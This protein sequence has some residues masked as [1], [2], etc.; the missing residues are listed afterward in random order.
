MPGFGGA[1]GAGSVG[2]FPEL[3]KAPPNFL[4]NTPG[5]EQAQGQALDTLAGAEGQY[6]I[7]KTM[8]PA[9]LGLQG[10]RLQTDQDVATDRLREDLANRGIFTPYGASGYSAAGTSPAGGGVG[11]ALYNRNVATP[12]GRQRQDLGAAGAGAYS[13]LSGAYGGAQLGYNQDMYQALLGRANDAFSAMPL[14]AQMGGYALPDMAM[15]SFSAPPQ[16]TRPGRT[17]PRKPRG[18]KPGGRKK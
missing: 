3:P 4:P 18:R 13:D 7:G 2:G 14:S 9:Q 5:F 15:P 8:I 10:A 1:A 12:F 17:R 16:S 11:Q 6:A